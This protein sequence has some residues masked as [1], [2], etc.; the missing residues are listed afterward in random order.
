VQVVLACLSSEFVADDGCTKL[1]YL[2]SSS[3][4]KA[5]QVILLGKNQNWMKTTDIGMRVSTEVQMCGLQICN[6]VS[7]LV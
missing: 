5:I 7:F 3:M 6:S 2:A 1:F 4:Q